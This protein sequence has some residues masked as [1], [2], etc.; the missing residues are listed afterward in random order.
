MCQAL[1]ELDIKS[2]AAESIVDDWQ[3]PIVYEAE[4]TTKAVQPSAHFV[5]LCWPIN[6]L[7]GLLLTGVECAR[8]VREECDKINKNEAAE[9]GE[10]EKAIAIT[11]TAV[12]SM[13][14]LTKAIRIAL[15]IIDML[16]SQGLQVNRAEELEGCPAVLSLIIEDLERFAE[17]IGWEDV[18]KRALPLSD[19]KA[20]AAHLV[21]TGKATA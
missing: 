18:N 16:K 5:R 17:E 12:D 7:V 10:A 4:T 11:R 9:E 19:F 20:L 13:N 8:R 21:E 3:G 2:R 14:R 1:Q 6:Q 15:S